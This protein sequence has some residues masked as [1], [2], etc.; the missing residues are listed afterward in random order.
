MPR[1]A[2]TQEQCKKQARA[3]A[4]AAAKDAPSLVS[5]ASRHVACQQE[6][7]GQPW[8][9]SVPPHLSDIPHK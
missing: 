9:L 7:L 5:P 8:E 1:Q 6:T 2:A 3:R 4:P